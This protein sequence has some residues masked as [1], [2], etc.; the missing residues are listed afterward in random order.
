LRLC[1]Q[2]FFLLFYLSKKKEG[3]PGIVLTIGTLSETP[4]FQGQALTNKQGGDCILQLLCLLWNIL[5][6]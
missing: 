4:L 1:W 5:A 3:E 6:A 2:F